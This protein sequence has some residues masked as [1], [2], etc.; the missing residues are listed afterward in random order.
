VRA[1]GLL[2]FAAGCEIVFPLDADRSCPADY[3]T[4]GDSKYAFRT[5]PVTAKTWTAAHASCI[6]EGV[7]G[8]SK[9]THLAVIDDDLEIA[10]LLATGRVPGELHI[11]LTDAV[12]EDT[13]VWVT[14]QPYEAPYPAANMNPPWGGNEP[15]DSNAGED[16][17]AMNE[18]GSF[19]DLACID[20]RLYLC[21]CDEFPSRDEP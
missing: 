11:G 20:V 10:E 21:E 19:N 5:D 4:V 17:V 18:R 8:S 6:V 1:V 7:D 15:N 12:V 9:F 2:L 3:E 16:C 13:F 14:D